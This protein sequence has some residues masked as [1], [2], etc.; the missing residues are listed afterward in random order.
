MPKKSVVKPKTKKQAKLPVKSNALAIPEVN[1][2]KLSLVPTIF[3][4]QQVLHM[5]Q[6]TPKEHVYQRPGK[7]GG[8]WNFVTGAYVKKSLNYIFGW[9]WNFEVV[10]KGREG[11]QVW[12]QG[13][14]TILNPQ[15]FAPMIIKEH[16]GRADMKF[17]KGTKDPLDYGNDLKAAA[18]DALKKCASE[19][20]IASDIYAGNEFKEIKKQDKGFTPPPVDESVVE[21]EVVPPSAPSQT[22]KAAHF[23][24]YDCA[25]VIDEQVAKF[26]IKMFKAPLCRGCQNERKNT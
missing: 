23:E 20:G 5:L 16:F 2:R 26:S 15:T 4:S 22:V 10:D 17:K 7:G 1:G 6:R 9:L 24:C 14:L 19:F 3:Q 25:E 11:D 13:R 18:T 21:G 12:V 8:T